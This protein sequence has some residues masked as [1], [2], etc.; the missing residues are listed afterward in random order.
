MFTAKP[1]TPS[2]PL[3][4]LNP[5]YPKPLPLPTGEPERE[6]GGSELVTVARRTAGDAVVHES[7]PT[8]RN[9]NPVPALSYA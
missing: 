7:N 6:R 4:P 5:L 9:P 3:D 8:H 1:D 2:L